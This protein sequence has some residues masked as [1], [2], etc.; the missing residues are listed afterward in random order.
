MQNTKKLDEIDAR[1]L[2]ILLC[3]SR[4]SFT[5][6]AKDCKIS[7]VAVKRRYMRLK[8]TGIINGEIMLINPYSLGYKCTVDLGIVTS[9]ENEQDVI[10]FL[11][12]KPYISGASENFG[13]YNIHAFLVLHDIEKLTRILGEIEAHP[14]VTRIDSLIW[15]ESVNMD[16]TENLVIKPLK[17]MPLAFKPLEVD[18]NEEKLDGIDKQIASILAQNSRMSFR[19]IAKQIGI[20]PK[21]VNQRFN[22]LMGTVLTKATISVDLN[23]IGYTAMAHVF[24]KVSN[25]SKMQEINNQIFQIPNLIVAIKLIGPYDVRVLVAVSDFEDL[26]KV[27]ETFR[28]I[29]G[30]EKAD[31]YFYRAFCI[32]PMNLFSSLLWEKGQFIHPFNKE[33]PV[34][35]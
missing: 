30:I 14:K 26:F 6:I 19:N 3:D 32:W 2:H 15:A 9:V 11:R 20:S 5:A 8:K 12:S 4:T 23:K 29:K 21:N 7:V 10:K 17:Q 13:R 24:V 34:E 35:T 31:T 25:R 22:R 28:R 33:Q 18:R 27:A 16:H 1:I